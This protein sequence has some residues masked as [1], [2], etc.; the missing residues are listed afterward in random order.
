MIDVEYAG[1]LDWRINEVIKNGVP[2]DIGLEELYRRPGQY[3]Y[4][5]RVSL[6]NDAPSGPI[7]Q[8]LLLKTNDP[9]TPLLPVLVEAMVQAPLTA[10]PATVSMGTPKVGEA[11]TRQRRGPWQQALQDHRRGRTRRRHEGGCAGGTAPCRSSS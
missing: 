6:K 10:V 1:V 3:G 11:V 5:V 8:E 7:K 2:V 9:T 4:R